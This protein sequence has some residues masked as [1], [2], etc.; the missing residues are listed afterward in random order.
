M[1]ILLVYWGECRHIYTE[2][3]FLYTDQDDVETSHQIAHLMDWID[4]TYLV[5]LAVAILSACTGR[6]ADCGANC[7]C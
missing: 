1:L 4:R 2:A 6:A 5:L 3:G 7:R